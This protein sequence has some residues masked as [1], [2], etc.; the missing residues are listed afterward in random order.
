MD[1]RWHGDDSGIVFVVRHARGRTG[2]IILD[3]ANLSLRL[4]VRRHGRSRRGRS[5][6]TAYGASA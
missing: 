5:R 1:V 2:E 3:G 4:V 6:A